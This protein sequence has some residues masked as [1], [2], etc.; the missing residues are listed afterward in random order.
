MRRIRGYFTIIGAR[1]LALA[2]VLLLNDASM[3]ESPSTQIMTEVMPL[4]WWAASMVLMGIIAL[5]VAVRPR[6]TPGRRV[7][8]ASIALTSAYTSCLLLAFVV[9]RA[10]VGVFAVLSAALVAKD[11]FIVAQPWTDPFEGLH[12]QEPLLEAR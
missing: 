1:H 12:L 6:E 10:V 8:I 4:S 3:S 11:F 5:F 9:D 2:A 7:A